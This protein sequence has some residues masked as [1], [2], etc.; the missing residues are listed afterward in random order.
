[1][2]RICDN[3]VVHKH[4]AVKGW[5]ARRRRPTILFTPTSASWLNQVEAFFNFFTRELVRGGV[6]ASTKELVDRIMYYMKSYD[7]EAIP[8]SCNYTGRPLTM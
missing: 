4:S 3:P 8:F 7:D 6:W 1:M 2:V 5:A